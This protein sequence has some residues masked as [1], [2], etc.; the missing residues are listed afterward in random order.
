MFCPGESTNPHVGSEHYILSVERSRQW[1]GWVGKHGT[2]ENEDKST[3]DHDFMGSGW[4]QESIWSPETTEGHRE[5]KA[6]T[7]KRVTGRTGASRVNL[8]SLL[9]GKGKLS[10]L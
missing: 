6:E 4:Q 10:S 3:Y 7:V 1:T 2:R 8:R 5:T 9:T